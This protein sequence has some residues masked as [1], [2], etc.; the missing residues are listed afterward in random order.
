MVKS[1]SDR[2]SK[3]RIRFTN[4][5]GTDRDIEI[6]TEDFD[7]SNYV[8]RERIES[9]TQ[10]FQSSYTSFDKNTINL[11]NELSKE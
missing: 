3:A 2:Y 1:K 11:M 7:P 10:S 4:K 8:K 6:D 5:N 9:S